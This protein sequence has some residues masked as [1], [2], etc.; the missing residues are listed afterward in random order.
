MMWRFS[1]LLI[2]LLGWSVTFQEFTDRVYENALE[3]LENDTKIK[4][5]EYSK[6]IALS[7]EP[8]NIGLSSR[9][10]RGDDSADSGYEFSL[11][12]EWTF[13]LPGL[14]H[15]QSAEWEILRKNLSEEGDFLRKIVSVNLKYEWLRYEAAMIRA[16]IYEKKAQVSQKGYKAGKKQLD[17]GR[18]SRLELMRLE[19]E[20]ERSKEETQKAHMEAEHIQH[21][22]QE[23]RM[24]NEP[25]HIDDLSFHTIR[26][27]EK[28]LNYV[29][30]SPAVESIR[31]KIAHTDA[32]IATARQSR[33][34]SY[35]IG[36]G[37]TQEP[38]QKSL[39]FALNI[40]ISWQNRHEQTIAALMHERSSLEYQKQNV[41]EKL[42]IAVEA[43]TE[44]LKERESMMHHSEEIEK[45][46][47]ALF[48]MSQK[49]F[50]G[51]VMSQF[52]YLAAKKEYFDAQLRSIELREEYIDELY[53]IESKLGVIVQ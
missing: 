47:E 50:E 42:R 27:Y 30:G 8:V 26:S 33:I 10:I 46:Y 35:S 43:L 36:V 20:Y 13:K 1:L 29:D 25:V 4:S 18:M 9:K 3:K 23:Q 5:V 32:Q 53:E 45:K 19:S 6:N 37:V 24:R 48:A 7:A 44:H 15:V 12:S 51:G 16:A 17:A 2:P 22:L 31:R 39:D 34:E 52:E 40:P 49:A 41:Q 28:L 38:T 21:R 14:R 11:M